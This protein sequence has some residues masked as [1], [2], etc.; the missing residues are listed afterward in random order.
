M[1]YS[2]LQKVWIQVKSEKSWP[3]LP[4]KRVSAKIPKHCITCYM[5]WQK[6]SMIVRNATFY[7][8]NMILLRTP[9]P[10]P[11]FCKNYLCTKRTKLLYIQKWMTIIL[12]PFHVCLRMCVQADYRLDCTRK[13]CLWT[14]FQACLFFYLNWELC[15]YANL[16]MYVHYMHLWMYV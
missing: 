11:A 9:P 13:T 15:F 10:P 16:C 1:W 5:I 2:S 12:W 3:D 7:H 8:G 14:L 6:K 4:Q